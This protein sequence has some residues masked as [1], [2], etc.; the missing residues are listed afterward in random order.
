MSQFPGSRADG[1][2]AALKK[3]RNEEVRARCRALRTAP[4]R[5]AGGSSG[6]DCVAG[7][8]AVRREQLGISR[9]E[10]AFEADYVDEGAG[11]AWSVLVT[12][13]ADTITDPATVKHLSRCPGARPWAGGVREL[14]IR[15]EPREVSGRAIET[16]PEAG[17]SKNGAAGE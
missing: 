7:R 16:L 2:S 11:V 1:W 17:R 12:G 9:E 10:L 6:G 13:S 4:A 15:V 8:I 3:D 5:P 14:W